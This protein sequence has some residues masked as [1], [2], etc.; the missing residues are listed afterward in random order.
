MQHFAHKS[1]NSFQKKLYTYSQPN[2]GTSRQIV[3][4]RQTDIVTDRQPAAGT[5]TRIDRQ[6]DIWEGGIFGVNNIA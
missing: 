3:R 1:F 5:D 2:S 6:T 4:D